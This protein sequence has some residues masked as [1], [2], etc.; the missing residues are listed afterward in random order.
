MGAPP[1]RAVAGIVSNSDAHGPAGSVGAVMGK[2]QGWPS[3]GL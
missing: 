1:G 2:A 3:L